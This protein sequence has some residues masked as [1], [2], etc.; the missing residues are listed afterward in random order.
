MR[1][2]FLCAALLVCA[3]TLA[4]TIVPAAPQP[5]KSSAIT[6]GRP[7][8]VPMAFVYRDRVSDSAW[9]ASHERARGALVKEFGGRISTIAVEN[10]ATAS[11][12]DRVFA[13]L[14]ARGYKVIFAT[15]T[16]H[17]RA[18][19]KMAAADFDVKVEQVLG[20]QTLINLRTF[21]VRHVEQAYLAG[22]IAAGHSRSRKLGVV[23]AA[24]TPAVLLE[25]KAF[26]LGAQSVDKRV[27]IELMWSGSTHNFDADVRAAE[28]LISRGVD[29]LLSVNDTDA[30]ARVAERRKKRVI[31]WHVD[32]AD[33]APRAQVAAVVLDWAPFYR[34][35]VNESFAYVCTKSDASRGFKDG[36]IKVVGLSNTMP[37]RAR[38]ALARAQSAFDRGQLAPVGR[39]ADADPAVQAV[40]AAQKRNFGAVTVVDAAPVASRDR[41]RETKR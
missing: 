41:S 22:I 32:R 38:D 23:A 21:E 28:R 35:A 9:S 26:A 1:F 13:E 3:S 31:G 16:V 37:A 24:A 8:P 39:E 2:F 11:D 33:V 18:S 15:D 4:A 34:V 5:T 17:A 36:A 40:P 20:T 6:L 27:A 7:E 29:V 19:A 14:A 10:V 25:I 12:A 30:V